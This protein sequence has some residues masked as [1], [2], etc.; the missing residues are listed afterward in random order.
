MLS[1]HCAVSELL[2]SCNEI[3]S[4]TGAVGAVS[5]QRCARND[6]ADPCGRYKDEQRFTVAV[7]A[8]SLR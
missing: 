5:D 1:M 6:A 3:G 4:Q 7:H 2:F 8:A